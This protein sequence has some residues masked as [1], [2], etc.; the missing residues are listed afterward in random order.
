VL[1]FVQG[2]PAVNADVL[3]SA[4]SAPAPAPAV[5]LSVPACCDPCEAT[6]KATSTISRRGQAAD[7]S[8]IS[9]ISDHR[10]ADRQHSIARKLARLPAE[11]ETASTHTR[12]RPAHYPLSFAR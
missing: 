8:L 10:A 6:S 9:R 3:F 4:S 12:T 5:E 1:N 11:R 2:W 7:P